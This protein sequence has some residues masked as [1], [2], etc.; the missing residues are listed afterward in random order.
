MKSRRFPRLVGILVAVLLVASCGSSPQ[1]EEGGTLVFAL[2]DDPR[3]LDPATT[4]QIIS[5]QVTYQMFETLVK[6]EPGGTRIVAGL[7]RSWSPS[8]DG[9]VWTFRLEDGVRFHDGTTLDAG[10]VCANFE[11]WYRF[12]GIL[13]SPAVSAVWQT[14]FGGFATKDL[15]SAPPSSL[16][17]SC[18]ASGALDA[19]ITLSRPSG[20]FLSA[21][22]SPPFS[23]ASPEPSA[24]TRPT[25]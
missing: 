2:L 11:R 17:Q 13:Q 5:L 14:V 12:K 8:A 23:I 6:L 10:A 25:R 19:V 21:L 1:S 20:A 24:G 3:T 22:A 9:R 18:E 7:A 16:Y 4:S 15:P